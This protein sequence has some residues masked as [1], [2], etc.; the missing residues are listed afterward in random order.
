MFVELYFI[1]IQTTRAVKILLCFTIGCIDQDLFGATFADKLSYGLS[2]LCSQTRLESAFI[3]FMCVN[4]SNVI[5]FLFNLANYFIFRIA[6]A[7]ATRK[8]ILSVHA[9]KREKYYD[10]LMPRLCLC[11]YFMADTKFL[12]YSQVRVYC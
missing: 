2:D 11:R 5:K 6:A 7:I 8:F 3:Q 10:V 9:S 4:L 1:L 12:L